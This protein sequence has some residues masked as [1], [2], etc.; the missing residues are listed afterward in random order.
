MDIN[1]FT[2]AIGDVAMKGIDA[3]GTFRFVSGIGLS[4]QRNGFVVN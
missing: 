1:S 3:L 2:K 4:G